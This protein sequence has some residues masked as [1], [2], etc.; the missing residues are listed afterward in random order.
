MNL[1][2][3]TIFV[4]LFA[5]SISVAQQVNSNGAVADKKPSDDLNQQLPSWLKLSGEF[6][7]RFEEFGSS[8]FMNP[9]DSY[10]LTRA[11][12][13]L[14]IQPVSWLRFFGQTQDARAFFQNVPHPAP[15][16]QDT[17]D[18]RQAFVEVGKPEKGPVVLRAGRQEINLGD[19]RLVGSLEWTNTARSF[20][21]V[22]LSLRH[23]GYRLDA[24][25]SS[26]V[27]QRDQELNH[28]KQ[29]NNLHGLYGGLDSLFPGST[30]E[31]YILWRLSPVSLSPVTEH[32]V[33]GKLNEKTAGVRWMGK[34]P[35]GFDYNVEMAKQFGSLGL[36][37]ISA[38]AGHWLVGKKFASAKWQ[39]R[40]LVEYNYASGDS[41]PADGTRGTFDQL[42]PTGHLKYGLTDQVGWRNIHDV[43]T[44]I[45]LKLSR[46]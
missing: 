7:L 24:F 18:I 43:H 30:I 21:A 34:L 38:W 13:N 12:F 14:S 28:H 23:S 31:P 33:R 8:G 32:G 20:D 19:Q 39:P 40:W 22:R 16:Y 37:P 2:R 11:R 36:D 5:A 45:E 10:L 27:D 42:Y 17:W 3:Q 15:P 9:E 4:L 6:R 35:L 26:V 1:V 29:G 46:K 25:A 44:G 41:S